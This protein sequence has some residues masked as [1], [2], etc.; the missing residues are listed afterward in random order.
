MRKS[1]YCGKCGSR[2]IVL[3]CGVRRCQAWT[4]DWGRA[5][6]HRSIKRR[7]AQ[8]RSY[9]WRKYG[10]SLEQIEQLFEAQGGRC[11]FCQRYWK[12]CKKANSRY[13]DNFLQYAIAFLE[14]DE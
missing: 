13:D 4:R 3:S 10:I 14:E 8:R 12:S 7:T 11:A 2:K 6:Y 5:Y 1:E 9:L